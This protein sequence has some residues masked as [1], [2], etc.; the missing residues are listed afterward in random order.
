MA[1]FLTSTFVR[2][3]CTISQ[4]RQLP[5]SSSAPNRIIPL[6]NLLYTQTNPWVNK[7]CKL[8]SQHYCCKNNNI[9][10]NIDN[11]FKEEETST[12]K[13]RNSISMTKERKTTIMT[14][15]NEKVIYHHYKSLSNTQ[16][17]MKRLLKEETEDIVANNDIIALTASSQGSG[18]G[19]RGRTWLGV[20]GNLYL[21]IAIPSSSVLIPIT[22]LPLKIGT[23][24]TNQISNFIQMQNSKHS[25][26]ATAAKVTVKWPN[27]ILI[28]DL[29]A[30]GILIEY[31]NDYFLI[32]IGCNI[33]DAPNIDSAGPQ[34]GRKA[35][36]L[37]KY[38]TSNN[39]SS[40]EKTE[41]SKELANLIISDTANWI[42]H[43]SK[44]N[45]TSVDK[46]INDWSTLFEFGKP[47]ILRDETDNEVVLPIGIELDG[48]LKVISEK[49]GKEVLL[50]A[51]YLF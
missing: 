28:N 13:L 1:V 42:S 4:I 48:R 14:I 21:T 36:S 11:N 49:D 43:D 44:Y 9:E 5:S 32:G 15:G 18:R 46:V 38:I 47:Y 3:C 19:T 50:V 25:T 30:S 27:D 37:N 26:P 41:L 2:I 22:L 24:V 34:R 29:K 6:Q 8:V 10:N 40:I 17:E 7:N 16:D 33:I 51:D 35:T 23:I 39:L 31:S 20:P 12:A 45:P